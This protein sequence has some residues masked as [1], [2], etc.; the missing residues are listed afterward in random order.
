MNTFVRL[1]IILISVFAVIAGIIVLT[2]VIFVNNSKYRKF[3][4]DHCESLKTLN[5]INNRYKF[6]FV[7]IM[8]MEHSY[9]NEKMYDDIS[10]A[11]YLIYQLQF[12]KRDIEEYIDLAYS[13]NSLYKRYN[14]EI[15]DKCVFSKYDTLEA[16]KNKDKLLSIEKKEFNKKVMRPVINFVINVRLTLTTIDGYRRHHKTQSFNSEQL[17]SLI[18][19]VNDKRGSYYNQSYIWDA[20]CRVER[21]K[22]SNKMR[23]AIYNRDHYRCCI[24]G[25]KTNDLEI[26]HI[27][28][29][30]KGGKSTFDNLQT[31]CHR[32]NVRKGANVL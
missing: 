8:D 12:K 18:E 9:D 17:E 15:I 19:D 11:D 25:R 29:I 7:P 28:P 31:L 10:C 2:I 26:D 32:C 22:V 30:S 4:N 23:F 24:C 3:V 27:Y 5:D 13:N 16:L 21:G 6:H 20:I 1:I 14:K